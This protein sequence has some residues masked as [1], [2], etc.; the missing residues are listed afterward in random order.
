[1]VDWLVDLALDCFGELDFCDSAFSFERLLT[2]FLLPRSARIL[3]TIT[4]IYG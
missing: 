1:M 4:S 2:G 3:P